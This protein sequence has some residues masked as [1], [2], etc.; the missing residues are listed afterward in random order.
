MD[1]ILKKQN[2][3]L[4]IGLLSILLLLLYHAAKDDFEPCLKTFHLRACELHGQLF[5]AYASCA[6]NRLL[7]QIAFYNSNK[8]NSA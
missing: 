5:P 1:G 6:Q 7:Q 2:I 3:F 4:S 8:G